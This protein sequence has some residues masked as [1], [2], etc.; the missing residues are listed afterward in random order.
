MCPSRMSDPI[1]SVGV[2][3]LV[4]KANGIEPFQVFVRS[5]RRGLPTGDW[6][7]V[8]IF[9]GFDGA[10]D[11]RAYLDEATGLPIETLAIPDA[12]FDISSYFKAAQATTFDTAVFFNSFSEILEPRWF[13]MFCEHFKR[14]DVG[15]VGATGSLESVVRNHVVYGAAEHGLVNKSV[16]YAIAAGLLA[17]FP[18]FPNPHIRTNAFMIRRDHFLATKK[19]PIERR[20]ASLFYESGWLSLTRQIQARGLEVLVVNRD[21]AGLE[22]DAWA[23][24]KAFRSGAQDKLLVEDNRVREYADA[25]ADRQRLL[26]KLAFGDGTDAA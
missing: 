12:G 25:T 11:T 17:L 9:K 5:L 3:H 23:T 24:A 6:K 14:P 16:K 26:R 18:P 13:E 2:F 19:F 22:P 7:L 4:R 1:G 10:D 8:L 15:L 20:L 21:G